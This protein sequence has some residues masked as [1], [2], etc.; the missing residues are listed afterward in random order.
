M[1]EYPNK[2][3][4][5]WPIVFRATSLLGFDVSQSENK[6]L[7]QNQQVPQ[8]IVKG[9]TTRSPTFSFLT[10]LPISTTSPMGSWPRTSPFSIVGIKPS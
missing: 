1:W 9:T 8:D 3:A 2:P 5:D 6:L 7:S 4:G 10:W